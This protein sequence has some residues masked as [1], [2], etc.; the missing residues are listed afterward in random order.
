MTTR[1][2]SP[3]LTQEKKTM[4]TAELEDIRRSVNRGTPL[5]NSRWQRITANRLGLQASLNP[6]GRP[7][8]KDQKQVLLPK[9]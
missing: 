1:D 5:G 4:T 3:E 9:T 2:H 6:R 8:K 7:P